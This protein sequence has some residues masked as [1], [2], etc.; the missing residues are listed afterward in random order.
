MN[1][2]DVCSVWLSLGF[3]N[4]WFGV[5]YKLWKL[6][7][8]FILSFFSLIIPTVYILS[9]CSYP[10]VLHNG[11][12]VLLVSLLF[13][14]FLQ[15]AF[16]SWNFL[17]TCFLYSELCSATSQVLISPLKAALFYLRTCVLWVLVCS[18][19]WHASS[20]KQVEARGQFA[21]V[22]ALISPGGPGVLNAGLQALQQ[23]PFPAELPLTL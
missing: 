11:I 14:F 5:W 18:I 21:G 23:A 19:H 4:V 15:S 6:L 2:F 16:S 9:F 12:F 3:L 7:V 8:R 1:W 13:N 17:L 10:T 22:S 20:E